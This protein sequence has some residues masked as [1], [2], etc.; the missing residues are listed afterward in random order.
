MLV[1]FIEEK[2]KLLAVIDPFT[3]PAS[4]FNDYTGNL[5]AEAI[6]ERSRRGLSTGILIEDEHGKPVPLTPSAPRSSLRSE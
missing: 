3:I 5:I 6:K 1:R 2:G 4:Q